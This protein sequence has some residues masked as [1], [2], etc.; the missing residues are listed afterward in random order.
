MWDR[1]CTAR[2]AED[3]IK[4][5]TLGIK[6]DA[7]AFFRDNEYDG[8]AM[9]NGY[10]LPGVRI[11]PA[12]TYDPTRAVHLELGAYAIF[13]DGANKYPNYAYHDITTWKGTQY[14][15]GTHALPFFRAAA[16]F[17]HVELV[18]GDIYGAQNHQLIDPIYNPELNI[19]ADPEM[20][21]QL[22][23]DRR[24]VHFDAWIDWQ[25]YIYKLD[26]HQ[27]AFTVGGNAVIKWGNDRKRLRWSIPVE[28]LI[29]HRGGEQD[30]THLGVQ[31]LANA[32]IGLRMDYTPDKRAVNRLRAEVNALASYQQSGSLWP[33]KT[34]FAL[35]AA[36]GMTLFNDLS[37][38]VGYVGAPKQFAN[39]FGS[40][41]FSTVSIKDDGRRLDGIH[42]A[43]FHADYTYAFAQAY[44]LGAEVELYSPH[45]T[46]L[47]EF[48]FH[49]GV[50]FRV[51]PY[52]TLKRFGKN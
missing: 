18:F 49:F 23:L 31:T 12:L 26:S 38:K 42:T 34:G 20:G 4:E 8:S 46:G 43:Y 44:K 16:R 47:N 45:S 52:F 14:K 15:H 19:S 5:N 33:F 35:H 2:A 41:F 9:T 40:P 25:S 22:L 11:N 32:G 24:H 37:L 50:Y 17:K 10:T 1:L 36:F 51:C 29:Q 13:Y 7:V 3:S 39:L 30:T 27:E 48:R 21:F 6:F 28:L